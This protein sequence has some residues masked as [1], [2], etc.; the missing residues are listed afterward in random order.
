M[1]NWLADEIFWKKRSLA[2]GVGSVLSLNEKAKTWTWTFRSHLGMITQISNVFPVQIFHLE[3]LVWQVVVVEAHLCLQSRLSP[4]LLL[5]LLLLV[6]P[7]NLIPATVLRCR[8][9]IWMSKSFCHNRHWEIWFKSANSEGVQT[10]K[11]NKSTCWHTAVQNHWLL[12]FNVKAIMYY[13][14]KMQ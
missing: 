2:K 12:S 14:I 11:Q 9:H 5:L 3:R 7:V 8:S 6:R 10:T 13:L 4:I 1:Q